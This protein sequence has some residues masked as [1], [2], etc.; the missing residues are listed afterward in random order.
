M[1][2]R[3]AWTILRLRDRDDPLKRWAEQLVK[4]RGKRITVV[5][6][7]RKLAGVL[8]A[9]WRDGTV[10]DGQCRPSKRQEGSEIQHANNNI[11]RMYSSARPRSYSA[12]PAPQTLNALLDA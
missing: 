1:L 6:L 9:M 3:A 7:A 4:T 5:A 10:Y 11:E 12:R 2:V 8:W